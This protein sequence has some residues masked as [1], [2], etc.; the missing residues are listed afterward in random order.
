[1]I[2]QAQWYTDHSV[3]TVERYCV[4]RQYTIDINSHSNYDFHRRLNTGP[5]KKLKVYYSIPKIPICG[6]SNTLKRTSQLGAHKIKCMSATKTPVQT[7][8]LSVLVFEISKYTY[9]K[10]CQNLTYIVASIHVSS[11]LKKSQKNNTCEPLITHP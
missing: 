5:T 6:S 1:M 11:L 9:H 7:R 8:V 2:N 3:A 4:E 10:M